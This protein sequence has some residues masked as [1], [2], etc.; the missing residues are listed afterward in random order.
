MMCGTAENLVLKWRGTAAVCQNS[1]KK[2]V[3]DV[4]ARLFGGFSGTVR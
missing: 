1:G 2:W 4:H 3:F